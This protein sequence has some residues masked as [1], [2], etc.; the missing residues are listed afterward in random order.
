[1][2]NEPLLSTRGEYTGFPLL[3]SRIMYVVSVDLQTVLTIPTILIEEQVEHLKGICLVS[4]Q[5]LHFQ[6]ICLKRQE[7]NSEIQLVFI[8]YKKAFDHIQTDKLCYVMEKRG[9]PSHLIKA[10][11]LEQRHICN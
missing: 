1:M 3:E 9:Y 6:T 7:L 2:L 4:W 11:Q 8:D 5:C 10:E